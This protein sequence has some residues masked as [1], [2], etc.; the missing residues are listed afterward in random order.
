MCKAKELT[1]QII[2]IID[3]AGNA[4]D[5]FSKEQSK[6]DKMTE[7]LLHKIELTSLSAS[8]GYKL[9]KQL[10]DIR[11]GR[12]EIKDEMETLLKLCKSSKVIKQVCESV[13]TKISNIENQQVI[14]GYKPRILKEM[15]V[16]RKVGVEA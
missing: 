6:F 3:E 7:D 15:R 4:Y 2:S 1:D 12:R 13:Q 5:S 11:R 14:R 8:D 9:C 10:Q 16:K